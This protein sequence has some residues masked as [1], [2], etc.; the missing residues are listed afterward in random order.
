LEKEEDLQKR[1]IQSTTE[2]RNSDTTMRDSLGSEIVADET[3]AVAVEETL[4]S[5]HACSDSLKISSCPAF[6]V[7]NKKLARDGDF[8][9]PLLAVSD[10]EQRLMPD[11][12]QSVYI[13]VE[14]QTWMKED[15]V[16]LVATE[17]HS[18]T[19]FFC[20]RYVF[21]SVFL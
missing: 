18:S 21:L 1:R 10:Q 14:S 11:G 7:E 15:P 5:S 20:L 3:I 8:L 17:T 4:G 2:E 12:E 9:E 6:F 19:F 16:P 13:D